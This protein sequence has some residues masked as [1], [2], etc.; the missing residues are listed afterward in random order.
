[1]SD[2]SKGESLQ[3]IYNRMI[4]E[5]AAKFLAEHQDQI[6]QRVMK[7]LREIRREEKEESGEA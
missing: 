7:R 2:E 6:I 4:D 5:E 1:M 3:T